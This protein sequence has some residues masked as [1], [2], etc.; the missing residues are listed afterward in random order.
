MAVNVRCAC[1]VEY[2]TKHKKCPTCGLARNA[3]G[4]G[5]KVIIR[6]GARRHTRLVGNLTLARQIEA[7]LKTE[8][9]Q[10]QELGVRRAPYLDDAWKI[11]SARI[12]DP[13]FDE[14]KKSWADDYQR[15][16]TFIA[17]ALGKM[18]MNDIR[19]E[20][21]S[22]IL[23]AMAKT[24]NR[25]GRVYQPATQ[26]QVLMLISR[27]YNWAIAQD[28]YKGRNPAKQLR[29]EVDNAREV[30]LTPGQCSKL[31]EVMMGYKDKKADMAILA[32]MFATYTGRRRSEIFN[33]T[34]SNVNQELGFIL[35]RKTKSGKDVRTPLSA[36][37]WAVI[38]ELENLRLKDC[39]LVWHHPDGSSYYAA[40]DH[41][42]RKICT[43]AGIPMD[44]RFHDLRHTFG[45]WLGSSHEV[46]PAMLQKL[47]GHESFETTLKYLHP[48]N[49]EMQKAVDIMGAKITKAE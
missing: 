44:F 48:V 42:W 10:E 46:A 40:L 49:E 29:I 28:R 17:P 20:D 37:A 4:V 34:W 47:M 21:I 15:W 30:Y 3:D 27:L 14:F 13:H 25:Y 43:K 39:P 18:R 31:F 5:Y 45:T 32:I 12:K 33:L 2:S 1:K 26:R 23:K 9:V 38:K 19:A 35:F 41:H 11:F 36:A 7:K 22:K 6:D 8:L 16:G 24:K